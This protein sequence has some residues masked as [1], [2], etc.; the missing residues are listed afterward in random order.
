[1]CLLS[2]CFSCWIRAPISSFELDFTLCFCRNSSVDLRL[3]SDQSHIGRSVPFCAGVGT[4]AGTPLGFTVQAS[5]KLLKADEVTEKTEDGAPVGIFTLPFGHTDIHEGMEIYLLPF[6]CMVSHARDGLASS[7]GGAMVCVLVSELPP[8]PPVSPSDNVA[9]R[10]CICRELF[11][12][13]GSGATITQRSDG[14]HA[15]NA[16]SRCERCSW[17]HVR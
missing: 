4:D 17:R 11:A 9:V 12:C 7:S 15:M 3:R 16:A 10:N 8:P 1:V 14:R 5:E 6:G 13:T 2:S